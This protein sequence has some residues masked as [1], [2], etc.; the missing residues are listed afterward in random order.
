MVHFQNGKSYPKSA[1]A[2]HLETTVA[3]PV[4]G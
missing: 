3:A 2:A 1:P 4:G